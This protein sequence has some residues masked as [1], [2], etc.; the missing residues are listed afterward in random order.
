MNCEKCGK[1]H[2]GSYASGRFCNVVCKN[3]CSSM[4][5]R[6]ERNK[7]VSVTIQRLYAQGIIKSSLN[8]PDIIRKWKETRKKKLDSL[9][10]IELPHTEKKKRVL[11]KQ[12]SLCHMCGVYKWFNQLLKLELH[13][14]DGTNNEQRSNLC[15]L[16][17]NCHSQTKNSKHRNRKDLPLVRKSARDR[18]KYVLFAYVIE[19]Q[20]HRCYNCGIKDWMQKEIKFDLH[21]VDGN[22]ANNVRNNLM[23]LCPNCHSLTLNYRHRNVKIKS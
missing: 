10:W 18:S 21:H 22:P 17:L 6:E 8:N 7:K 1:E 9:P 11:I 14:I 20:S 23:F 16:C 5:R 4:I 15:F 3:S 2:D 12:N 19:E 13:H